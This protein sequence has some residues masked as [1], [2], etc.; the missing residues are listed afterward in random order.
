MQES[1][2]RIVLV[3]TIYLP[4]AI[5]A[6]LQEGRVVELRRLGRVGTS[7]LWHGDADALALG[8][9]QRGM[10]R[11]VRDETSYFKHAIP[12]VLQ[13]GRVVELRQLERVVTSGLWHGDADALALGKL[14]RRVRRDVRDETS[15]Y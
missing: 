8:K 2:Q 10:R 7:G 6:V 9:L 4:N 13:E 5:P 3:E 14:Q 11:D 1:L 12:A 15:Y